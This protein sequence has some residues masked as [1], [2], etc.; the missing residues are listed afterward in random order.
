MSLT[1]AIHSAKPTGKALSSARTIK[2]TQ[3][4]RTIK[5]TRHALQ[6][7]EAAEVAE[8]L[9]DGATQLVVVELSVVVNMKS[10]HKSTA[11]GDAYMDVTRRTQTPPCRLPR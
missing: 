8:S 9:R 7:A 3:K 10:K 4:P 11:G 6:G 5:R 2:H 1:Q